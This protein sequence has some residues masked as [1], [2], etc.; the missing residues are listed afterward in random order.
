MSKIVWISVGIFL[1][2]C[3]L[4]PGFVNEVFNIVRNLFVWLGQRASDTNGA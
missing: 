1:A 2:L 4:V 3:L